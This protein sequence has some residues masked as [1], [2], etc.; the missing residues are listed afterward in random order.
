MKCDTGEASLALR[1][2]NIVA[3]QL[4]EFTMKVTRGEGCDLPEGIQGALVPTYVG[5]SD[6]Q[7]AVKKGVAE[8]RG[9]HFVFDD[10]QGQVREIPIH[11][12]EEYVAQVW[13]EF[14]SALPSKEQL[15]SL[16]ENG[17]VFFGPFGGFK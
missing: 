16:V 4:Y 6:F 1:K 12:W 14:A 3:N 2:G 7:S 13:P 11:R 10:I 8:I 5:A 17:L 9:R 15:P